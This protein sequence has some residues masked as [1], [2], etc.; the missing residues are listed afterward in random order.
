[1]EKEC[2]KPRKWKYLLVLLWLSVNHKSSA[3]QVSYSLPSAPLSRPPGV[4]V[5]GEG[6]AFVSTG[7]QLFR[8]SRDLVPELSVNL[9]SDSVNIS[10]MQFWREPVGG[11]HY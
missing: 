3:Q 5:D 1:M 2:T 8:L 6:R 7:N 10:L 4:Q 9:S 11:V